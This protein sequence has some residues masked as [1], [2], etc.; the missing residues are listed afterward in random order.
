M[1]PSSIERNAHASSARE[2]HMSN[3]V[4]RALQRHLVELVFQGLLPWLL[5]K[6]IPTSAKAETA[7]AAAKT[8]LKFCALSGAIMVPANVATAKPI[9][10]WP[11]GD[12]VFFCMSF[13][14]VVEI[15]R[16]DEVQREG[17]V[18]HLIARTLTD[19]TSELSSVG[20]RNNEFPHRTG[21]GD[22][23]A[24]GGPGSDNRVKE[25]KDFRQR[26]IYVPN[27]HIDSIRIRGRNFH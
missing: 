19:L 13:L 17:E 1:A 2:G 24:H 10:N 6:A 5:A 12:V 4:L 27:L 26:D 23:F 20:G 18:V 8:G 14:H 3:T 25:P 21:R 7:P 9:R 15:A 16:R 22:E 11:S